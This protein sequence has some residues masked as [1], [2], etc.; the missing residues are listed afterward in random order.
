MAQFFIL[1]KFKNK[2]VGRAVM[3]ICF[4]RFRGRWEV[5]VMPGNEGAYRFW[6]SVITERTQ[7]NFTEA[8]RE[9][10]HFKN[11]KNIFYFDTTQ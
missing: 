3:N 2:G 11:I 1:R 9:V 6:R 10:S 4:D 8:T 5:M 7:N